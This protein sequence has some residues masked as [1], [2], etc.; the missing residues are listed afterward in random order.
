VPI[1]LVVL[2]VIIYLVR[3]RKHCS[4][5]SF[6]AAPVWPNCHAIPRLEDVSPGCRSCPARAN[7]I[8][9]R[10][11][12]PLHTCSIVAD[13]HH[14][15]CLYATVRFAQAFCNLER[16]GRVCAGRSSGA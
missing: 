10:M 7:R 1:Q 16:L 2:R 8:A 5:F 4:S 6:C 11:K 15:N 9:V 3:M 13:M 12:R 14:T